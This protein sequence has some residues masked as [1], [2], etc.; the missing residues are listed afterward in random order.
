[1][2]ASD[3]YEATNSAHAIALLTEWDEFTT[4]DWKRIK[5][6]MMKP[7]FIFDGRKLLDGNYLRK[8]GFKYYAIGQ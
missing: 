5:D 4:Y 1:T 2:V 7:P 3:P 6:S 8:I